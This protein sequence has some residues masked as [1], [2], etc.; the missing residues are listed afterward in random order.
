MT[1][2]SLSDS[3]NFCVESALRRIKRLARFATADENADLVEGSV[4]HFPSALPRRY[5]FGFR[6]GALRARDG[7]AAARMVDAHA[8]EASLR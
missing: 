7:L 8:P 6:T 5:R 3:M 1:D 4:M 2:T